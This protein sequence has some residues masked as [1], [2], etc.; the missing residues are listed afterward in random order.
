MRIAYRDEFPWARCSCGYLVHQTSECPGCG[1][2]EE[3]ERL[4]RFSPTDSTD[5]KNR[6]YKTVPYEDRLRRF[7]V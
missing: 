5:Y 2:D 7:P 4:E 6:I 1:K 3:A